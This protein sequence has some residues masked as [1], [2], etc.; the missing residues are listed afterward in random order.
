MGV[1]RYRIILEH[2]AKHDWVAFVPQRNTDAGALT[3]YFAS[4]ADKDEFKLRGI[5]C[6]QR[7]IPPFI[8]EEQE[9]LVEMLDKHQ[10]PEPVC[11]RLQHELSQL[12]TGDLDPQELVIEQ[13]T[14]KTAEEYAHSTRTVAVL[15]RVER[16]GHNLHPGQKVDYV[17][18]DDSKRSRDRV[19]L[20]G[21]P[22]NTM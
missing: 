4:L 6:R 2:E 3:K 13:R 15:E 12:R 20:V 17:V 9:T 8:V 5:E 18:V 22:V 21:K 1:F 10:S 19:Q 7:S 16:E 14:S 11:N